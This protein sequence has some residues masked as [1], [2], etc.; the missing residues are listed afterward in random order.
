[1]KILDY[2][3]IFLSVAQISFV[4]YFMIAYTTDSMPLFVFLLSVPLINIF[5]I[6]KNIKK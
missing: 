4:V 1:M 6:V 5:A 2:L 3:A